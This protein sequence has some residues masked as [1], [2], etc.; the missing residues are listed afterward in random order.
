MGSIPVIRLW[1][2]QPVIP[3]GRRVGENGSSGFESSTVPCYA[4]IA[5]AGRATAFQAEGRQFDSG[6]P[7]LTVR[8]SVV[9]RRADNAE[10]TGSIPVGP[11]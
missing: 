1:N 11:I 8:S 6:C 2:G 7:L 4:G 5:H 10:V 3:V 9:E